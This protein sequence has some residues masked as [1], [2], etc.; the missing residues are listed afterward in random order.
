VTGGKPASSLSFYWRN[1]AL[2]LASSLEFW[3]ND[4]SYASRLIGIHYCPYVSDYEMSLN[5]DF[6]NQFRRSRTED[7]GVMI[8]RKT[9]DEEAYLENQTRNHSNIPTVPSRPLDCGRHF[10][11]LDYIVV[12]RLAYFSS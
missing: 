4:T 9:V 11:S 8:K 5:Q 6:F 7:K 12:E 2:F 10:G 1:L 3:I